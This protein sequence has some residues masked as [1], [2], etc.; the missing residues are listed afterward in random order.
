MQEQVAEERRAFESRWRKREDLLEKVIKNTAGM[1]GDLKG[2]LG[3]Q[4]GTV[5]YLELGDGL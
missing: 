1:H 3:S 4:L 2:M 5:E